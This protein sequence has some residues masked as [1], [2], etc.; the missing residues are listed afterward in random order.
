MAVD[1]AGTPAEEGVI[2]REI[3]NSQCRR[4]AFDGCSR[5]CHSLV[6][7]SLQNNTTTIIEKN[8]ERI[9]WPKSE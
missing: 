5:C 3:E 8:Y 2:F 4:M 6:A 7:S 1:D 9:Q